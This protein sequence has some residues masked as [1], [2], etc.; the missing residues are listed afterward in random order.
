MVT[1]IIEEVKN[2][3][4]LEHLLNAHAPLGFQSFSSF[5]NHNI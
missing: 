3:D 1:K 4:Y 2:N 5:T